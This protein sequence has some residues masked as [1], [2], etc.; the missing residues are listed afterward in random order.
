MRRRERRELRYFF[1]TIVIARRALIKFRISAPGENG[2][3]NM[4]PVVQRRYGELSSAL[5]SVGDCCR[6]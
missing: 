4:S 6:M 5:T 1:T 3:R 2:E